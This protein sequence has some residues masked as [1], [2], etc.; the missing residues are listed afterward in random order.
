MAKI[1]KEAHQKRLDRITE[2]FAGMVTHADAQ[3]SERCPYRNRLDECTAKI[4]CRNQRPPR[5][6]GELLTCGHD[7]GFD[8]R[9]AWD[10]DPDSYDRAKTRIG[11]IKKQA[12]D[13]RDPKPPAS[14]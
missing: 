11:D 10:S 2:L 12:A 9:D 3:A 8:Y 14:D 7:G 13:R 6:E 1:D 4:R 5:P